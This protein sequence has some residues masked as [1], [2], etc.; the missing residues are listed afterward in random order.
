MGMVG[1]MSIF[2][3]QMVVGVAAF[4]LLA[5][6]F[7][8]VSFVSQG[9]GI[10]AL[11]EIVEESTAEASDALDASVASEQGDASLPLGS[12]ASLFPP[13][14]SQ[15]DAGAVQGIDGHDAYRMARHA[16]AL[17]LASCTITQQTEHEGTE[18]QNRRNR[19]STKRKRTR[20]SLPFLYL[21]R[22]FIIQHI[23]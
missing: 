22:K 19:T 4:F 20:H 3:T 18:Q 14:S 21:C 23:T 7:Y 5:L 15:P 6:I 2:S 16:K 10:Q 11:S 13:T 9:F 1:A 12:A 17:E 8:A